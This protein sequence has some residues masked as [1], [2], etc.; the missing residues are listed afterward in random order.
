[1]PYERSEKGMD[2]IIMEQRL[3]DEKQNLIIAKY[4]SLARHLSFDSLTSESNVDAFN[5]TVKLF[6]EDLAFSLLITGDPKTDTLKMLTVHTEFPDLEHFFID[7]PC[8]REK[9]NSIVLGFF[10]ML[11][12]ECSLV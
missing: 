1:V 11:I 3:V 7:V 8:D 9:Y 12:E 10:N 4:P 6:F 2:F 5:R